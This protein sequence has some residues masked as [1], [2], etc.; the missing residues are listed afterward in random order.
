MASKATPTAPQ[1]TTIQAH[2][3][4]IY[5]LLECIIRLYADRNAYLA[6]VW[7]ERISN[8]AVL[9][10]ILHLF[11]IARAVPAHLMSLVLTVAAD[12]AEI[13]VVRNRAEELN[14][15]KQIACVQHKRER[16]VD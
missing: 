5:T 16:Q 2:G 1:P 15:G 3:L 6:D 4:E 12:V 11:R 14:W 8:L 9:L 10:E 13:D 7:P